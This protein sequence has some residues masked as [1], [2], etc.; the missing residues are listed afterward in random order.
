MSCTVMPMDEAVKLGDVFVTTTGCVDVIAEKRMKQ[1]KHNAIVCNIGHFDNE[2]GR[3]AQ[4]VQVDRD[5]AVH[6]IEIRA[7]TS[8]VGGRPL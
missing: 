1:V 5:H 6:S 7:A 2:S 8:F 4:E 3:Q